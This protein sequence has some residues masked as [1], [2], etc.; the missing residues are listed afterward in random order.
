MDIKEAV[1][2]IERYN[3]WRR[4]ADTEIVEPTILGNA[5]DTVIKYIKEKENIKD[6]THRILISFEDL[7]FKEHFKDAGK[8]YCKMGNYFLEQFED[9][10]IKEDFIK[11]FTEPNYIK[12]YFTNSVVGSYINKYSENKYWESMRF[13]S[14]TVSSSSFKMI[15]EHIEYLVSCAKILNSDE[16]ENMI[17]YNDGS[18][19]DMRL[20]IEYDNNKFESYIL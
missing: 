5:M 14:E 6:E 11:R 1:K 8:S 2:I 10:K 3:I 18:M 19:D 7:E 16:F 9:A 15:K 12:A 13:S 20:I 17:K 4:G